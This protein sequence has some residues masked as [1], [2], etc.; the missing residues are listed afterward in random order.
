M[1][2]LSTSTL[3]GEVLANI[4]QSIAEFLQRCGLQYK[5]VPLDE[6]WY[7][8]CCQE[9]TKRG[10]P[11]DTI[12]PYMSVGVAIT[13]NA[14]G[15][16]P[17]RP[18]KMWICLFT[19]VCTCMDDIMISGE[20]LVHLYRFNELFANCQPQGHPVLN[21]LDEL[22]REVACHY[23][24]PASN[25]I[26]TSALDFISSQAPSYPEYA[27]MLSGVDYAY[28]YF[29]FPSTLPP[30]EYVQCIMDV[31]MIVNYANDIL[32]YYKEEI[33][34]DTANYLSLMA[35]SRGLSK[36]DALQKLIEKTVQLHHGILEFLR[37]H[38]E[39]YD[40][41]VGFFNGYFKFHATFGRYK[42][43]EIM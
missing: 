3:D 33:Q 17:D 38:P 28:A 31:A 41:Y 39:A 2:S 1:N 12:L 18:T 9:A 29:V 5:N 6:T 22:L 15:H 7:S 19:A 20:N 4:R 14:Y 42:L 36:Q 13:S 10:Y 35:A 43:E 27:R 21:A 37:P 11:M 16:L 34:G 26:V 32:S 8:E 40:A 24:A 23:S 30:R 25:L